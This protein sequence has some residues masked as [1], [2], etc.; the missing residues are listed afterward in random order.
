VDSVDEHRP[1][2]VSNLGG[3]TRRMAC[4][5]GLAECVLVVKCA[6]DKKLYSFGTCF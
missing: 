2:S 3:C 6:F 1:S 5:T 4:S